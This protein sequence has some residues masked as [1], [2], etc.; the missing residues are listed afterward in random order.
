MEIVFEKNKV[1]LAPQTVSILSSDYI[2]LLQG[3]AWVS[4]RSPFAVRTSFGVINSNVAEYSLS[5]NLQ[6]ARV[7]VAINEV[8]LQSEQ[9]GYKQKIKTG[10]QGKMFLMRESGP[11][12]I[13]QVVSPERQIKM[14]YSLNPQEKAIFEKLVL[15]FLKGWRQQSQTVALDQWVSAERRIA[16]QKSE[17]LKRAA[18]R[19]A[20][21][22]EEAQMREL[23]RKKNSLSF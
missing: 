14:W 2:K 17:E 8:E 16:S 3:E 9:R 5:V 13:P 12:G 7:S 4:S 6:Q 15:Q 18:A 20:L 10:L 1:F 11:F 19:K 23:F 21:L 22:K